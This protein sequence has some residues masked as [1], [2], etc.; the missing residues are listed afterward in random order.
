MHRQAMLV[1][2]APDVQF[3]QMSGKPFT[4]PL[5]LGTVCKSIV[6][7]QRAIKRFSTRFAIL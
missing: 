3:H 7:A 5:G 6:Q 2:F 1:F 4:G